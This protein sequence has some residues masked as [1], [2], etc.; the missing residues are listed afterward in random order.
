MR[1][2]SC[3][4]FTAKTLLRYW[5]CGECRSISAA[6]MVGCDGC[7]K[8][9]HF[10]CA[11]LTKEPGKRKCFLSQYFCC[12]YSDQWNIFRTVQPNMYFKQSA[13][14]PRASPQGG[15]TEGISS[16]PLFKILTLCL[17]RCMERIDLKWSSSPPKWSMSPPVVAPWRRPCSQLHKFSQTMC[18]YGICRFSWM[19]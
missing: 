17:W 18:Q 2:D 9:Y 12:S 4:L 16:P 10:R 15:G 5:E 6:P 19:K 3:N 1:H 7:D 14:Q 11:G 8:W 13:S